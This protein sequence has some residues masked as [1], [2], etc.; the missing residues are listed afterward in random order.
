MTAG[1]T[2]LPRRGP[3]QI[4]PPGESAA[5]PSWEQVVAVHTRKVEVY[6]WA[7]RQVD[8]RATL[9]TPHLRTAFLAAQG[10]LHGRVADELKRDL[11]DLGVPPDEGASRPLATRPGA[12]EEILLYVCFY[13]ADQKNRDLAAG[14]SIWDTELVRGDIRVEPSTIESVKYSPALEALLPHADRFDEV[15]VLRFPLI[16][17]ESGKALFGPG[18]PPLRLEVRSALGAAVVEWTL[19]VP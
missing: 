15:Y 10:R 11:I 17:R 12:E 19:Q 5:A 4:L 9:V 7:V 18:E 1:C 6:E 8:L 14:Y 3:L 16:D 13:V 2:T